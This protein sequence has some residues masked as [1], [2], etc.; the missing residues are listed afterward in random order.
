MPNVKEILDY[1]DSRVPLDIKEDWDNVG[2]LAGRAGTQVNR[3]LTALDCTDEVIDEA[4]E[5]DA[6]LI[7]VHHPLVM[8][9]MSRVVDTDDKGRKIIK[10]IS[11]GISEIS[12]H[13]NLDAISGGVNDALITALG[14]ECKGTLLESFTT[15]GGALYGHGRYGVMP[16]EYGF[17]EFL[18]HAKAALGT[19]GLRYHDAG[20]PVR[21]IAVCGGTGGEFVSCAV[22]KGCDTYVTADIKYSQFIEAKEAGI[23]LIDGDHYCTENVVTPVL[24]GLIREG[25][26]GLEVVISKRHKQAASF[27][28]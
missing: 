3:V 2:L 6:Q 9:S 14:A 10:L 11:N 13:T 27:Y 12:L 1:L 25:F 24:A 7:V 18:E 20:R 23:N 4:I 5:L 17:A 28:I 15:P 19:A 16:R 26:P 8:K 22:E 21:N